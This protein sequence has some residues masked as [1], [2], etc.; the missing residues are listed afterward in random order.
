MDALQSQINEAADQRMQQADLLAFNE[1]LQAIQSAVSPAGRAPVHVPVPVAQQQRNIVPAGRL[2]SPAMLTNPHPAPPQIAGKCGGQNCL[3]VTNLPPSQRNAAVGGE[4]CAD[5]S[6]FDFNDCA[7]V[8]TWNPLAPSEWPALARSGQPP[9]APWHC[10][11]CRAFPLTASPFL[12]AAPSL[13]R[14]PVPV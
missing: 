8:K 4:A 3:N 13:S 2:A 1:A 11:R 9:A 6:S 12:L 14:S 5:Q 7:A 10:R